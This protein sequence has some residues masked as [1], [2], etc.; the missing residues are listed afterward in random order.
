MSAVG[1]MAIGQQA[2]DQLRCRNPEDVSGDGVLQYCLGLRQTQLTRD[3]AWEQRVAQ[4][5]EGLGLLL[6]ADDLGHQ[7]F[8][9]VVKS[10]SQCRVS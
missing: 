4:G 2:A 8:H 5:G 9:D 6:I 3:Q 7:R 10:L 1:T